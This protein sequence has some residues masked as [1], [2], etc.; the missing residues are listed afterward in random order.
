M[1]F[2]S[3]ASFT[4]NISMSSARPIVISGPSGSGK[5]TLLKKLF[6]DKPGQFGFSVS[7][8][9]RS[10]RAGEVDGKDYNFVDRDSF[11]ALVKQDGFIEHAEFSK[12]LYGTSV[13]AVQKVADEGSRCIL[14]ID[15][16]GVKLIKAHHL[17]TL[18]P[19][20]IF[21][22]PPSLA[23]LK[24]RLTNRGS[25]TDATIQSRLEASVAEVAYARQPNIY[26]FI[27]VNDDL[28]RAYGK[29]TKV[30][31]GDANVQ[32]DELPKDLHA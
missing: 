14:D 1:L 31:E 16:Q 8:T 23:E 24:N 2:R 12:N 9:T 32:S 10:P 7:H 6:A 30:V 3:F 13:A 25:E 4:R 22:S 5:S 17:E 20:F 21:L 29:L 18:N 28:D 19:I 27:I 26:D 11:L 15:S